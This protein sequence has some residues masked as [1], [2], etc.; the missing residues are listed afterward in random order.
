MRRTAVFNRATAPT[1]PVLMYSIV[2]TRK[3][4]HM[5]IVQYLISLIPWNKCLCTFN[6]IMR[7]QLQVVGGAPCT[8]RRCRNLLFLGNIFMNSVNLLLGKEKQPSRG[9]RGGITGKMGAPSASS[10]CTRCSLWLLTSVGFLKAAPAI[11][12]LDV[13]RCG[14]AQREPDRELEEVRRCFSPLGLK[15]H[16]KSDGFMCRQPEEWSCTDKQRFKKEAPVVPVWLL[17]LTF[18]IGH[19]IYT[20]PPPIN[21]IYS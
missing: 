19:V 1:P 10:P 14:E 3:I 16:Q 15:K 18:I 7:P 2:S 13:D 4:C 11:S 12:S 20:P 6:H 21:V 9:V 17:P 8:V 5:Y